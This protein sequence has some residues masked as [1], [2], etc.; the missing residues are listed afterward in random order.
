MLGCGIV[1]RMGGKSLLKNKIVE[2]FPEGYEEM[3]YIEPFVGGGSVLLKKEKSV[4]EIINDIDKDLITVY[5]GFKKYDPE[6]IKKDV[7]GKYSEKDFFDI[8]DSRPKSEYQKFIR[9][10]LLF[11]LSFYANLKSFSKSKDYIKLR[12]EYKDRLKDVKILNQSYEK[13]FK[14]DSPNSF[15]Y[16][17][18]PYEGS[19]K[20]HY[21][22]PY[23]DYE[24]LKDYLDRLRGKFLLS[25]NDSPYIRKLFKDYD[26]TKVKT[27]YTDALKGGQSRVKI[28]LLIKNY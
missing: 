9:M 27:K 2:E 3:I 5:K 19:D 17:D 10:F 16:L 1:G 12:V 23:I 11:R 15:F 22:N 18:P 25:I 20:E 6:K 21:E 28:E 24:E 4:K 13:L 7:N 8:M 26:I 14:Y